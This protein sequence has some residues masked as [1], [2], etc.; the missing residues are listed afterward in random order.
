MTVR[1][2]RV[3]TRIRE[4]IARMLGREEVRDPRLTGMVSITGVEVSRDLRHAR[5]FVTVMGS[6]PEAS[7]SGLRHATGF[8]RSRLGPRLGL[9]LVPELVF[10]ADHSLAYGNR[11]NE[12]LNRL[13]IPPA[14]EGVVE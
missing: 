7:L 9:R 11:M 1:T 12:L 8:I 3:A 4:E 10:E 5:V 6:D 14:E 2:E 13:E